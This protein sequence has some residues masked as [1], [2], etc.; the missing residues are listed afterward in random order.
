VIPFALSAVLEPVGTGEGLT[1]DNRT[2]AA[3]R[4]AFLYRG[5]AILPLG[6]LPAGSVSRF[7]GGTSGGSGGP[8]SFVAIADPGRRAFWEREAARIDRTGPVVV[9]WLDEPPLAARLGGSPAAASVC[10]VTLEV[11]ER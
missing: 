6:D 8:G 4:G 7:P 1:V 5:S 3:I 10:M 2:G 11:D 9:G